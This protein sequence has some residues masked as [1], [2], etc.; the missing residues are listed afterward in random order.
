MSQ[1]VLV[2]LANPPLTAVILVVGL[3]TTWSGYVVGQFKRNHPEVYAMDGVGYVLA[4]NIGR[5]LYSIVYPTFMVSAAWT[6]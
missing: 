1:A 2:S 5:E 4:G 6:R 3:L